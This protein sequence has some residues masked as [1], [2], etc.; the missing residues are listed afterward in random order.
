MRET[1]ERHVGVPLTSIRITGVQ[2]RNFTATTGEAEV[3]YNL[4]PSV[5]GNDNWVSYGYQDGRWKVTNCYA[6]IGGQSS[7]SPPASAESTS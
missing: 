7:S 6:P 3:Q 2:L 5:A 1:M 4:A